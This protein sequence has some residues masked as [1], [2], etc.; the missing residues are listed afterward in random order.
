M[1]RLRSC[2]TPVADRVAV[3]AESEIRD[4]A[5]AVLTPRFS[6][7]RFRCDVP[8]GELKARPCSTQDA[9]LFFCAL[10]IRVRRFRRLGRLATTRCSS[11]WSGVQDQRCPA[12]GRLATTLLAS[13]K[14]CSRP[15]TSARS[16][17]SPPRCSPAWSGVQDQI[18]PRNQPPRHHAAR[19]RGAVFKTRYVRAISR[20]ATTLLAS[21]E[22][23]SRP[24]TSP[25][26]A[27]SPPRCSP[28][29]C[30]VQDQIRP[31]NQPPRHHAACQRGA[32]FK[33]RDVREI[34]FFATTLLASVERCSRPEMSARSASSPPRCSPAWCGVQDQIR[35]RNQPPRHHAACQR[36]AVFKTRD[37]R[38]IGLFATTLLA[39]VE[40]CS[41]PDTSP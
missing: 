4:T 28:A 31:R 32:V 29:W 35:P 27:A 25:Q 21:V 14:R 18:R 19:Q 13:V 20:L 7:S 6:N 2:A 39:S 15:D 23:C 12:I 30:G 26:S 37:V 22:R 8:R 5:R 16:A 17:S 9:G 34:G 38:E 10:P 33:T 1:R 24:D 3:K 36:G 40:R 41:R 11:A